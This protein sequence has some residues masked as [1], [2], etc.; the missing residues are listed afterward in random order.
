M[1]LRK[2]ARSVIPIPEVNQFFEVK[3]DCNKNLMVSYYYRLIIMQLICNKKLNTNLLFL[4]LI[5]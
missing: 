2:I 5:I 1:L 3:P 4:R